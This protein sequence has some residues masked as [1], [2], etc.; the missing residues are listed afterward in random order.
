MKP[1]TPFFL[2]RE[3][4]FRKNIQDFKSGMQS[5]W[6]NT[7]LSYSVKTNS[8]PWV[9]KYLCSN[10]VS[11]EVVSDEEYD[12]A[13]LCGYKD[14]EIIFNGPCK[15]RKKL[16]E[17]VKNGARVNIDSKREIDWLV[18]SDVRHDSA[19]NLGIRI[20]L[21]PS[22]FDA[23]DIGYTDDGFRF[24][25][26]DEAGELKAALERL[27][28][29]FDVTRIGFHMH[30]N[31]VTRSPDVYRSIS[32][33]AV[34]V[35]EKYDIEPSYVDIGGGFFGGVPNKP[36]ADEYF[37]IIA[38]EFSNGFKL[39]NTLLIAEPGSALIGSVVD[40]YTSVID[41][42]NTGLSRIVTTDGS[43][44]HIDPL[45]IKHNYNYSLEGTNESVYQGKQIVCGYTCMDH[46]RLMSLDSK[47]ELAVGDQIIYHMVGAYSM[48]FG[49]PFIRYWP[50]VYVSIEGHLERVRTRMAVDDYLSVQS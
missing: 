48:T 19:L 8:L 40:L 38:E 5:N 30:C 46:D 12:L 34:A 1:Q 24:G 32:R 31:S 21:P 22:L 9:L 4:L 50:D 35:A 14:A 28:S 15:G 33:Y 20:N 7:L 11:A 2:I 44:I 16:I 37:R 42:K 23:G 17:A 39:R 43:R 18:E 49:G 25:F 36:K 41:V 47:Q 6:P 27:S 10:G 26:S 29:V 3:S 13:K 45:W